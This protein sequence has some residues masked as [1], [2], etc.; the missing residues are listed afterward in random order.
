M[1]KTTVRGSNP[2]RGKKFYLLQIVRTGS[3][4]RPSPIQRVPTFFPARTAAGRLV[5]R[6]S[7]PTA[8]VQ[9]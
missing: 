1:D 2:D 9:N 8:E 4:P 6:S 3:F 7:P 5:H